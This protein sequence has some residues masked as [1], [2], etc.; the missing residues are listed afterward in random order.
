MKH[1]TVLSSKPVDWN[2]SH[3]SQSAPFHCEIRVSCTKTLLTQ[4]THTHAVF[5]HNHE[6]QASIFR[7]VRFKCD[8]SICQVIM[9]NQAIHT[10]PVLFWDLN[11]LF[12]FKQTWAEI[13]PPFYLIP[14]LYMPSTSIYSH[15]FFLTIRY[16][17]EMFIHLLT[18]R[19]E[20]SNA[21]NAI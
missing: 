19:P 21:L 17:R 1:G 20:N 12:S 8:L 3:H 16:I 4:Y 10:Y 13:S 2:F 14:F 5:N 7:N 6:L 9:I 18:S 11:Y 15:I